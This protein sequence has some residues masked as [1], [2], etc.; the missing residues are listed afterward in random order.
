MPTPALDSQNRSSDLI[1]RPLR[2][3]H[4]CGPPYVHQEDLDNPHVDHMWNSRIHIESTS[5]H[6]R[7]PQSP[8]SPPVDEWLTIHTM[9]T[10]VHTS[11]HHSMCDHS[12]DME[13]LPVNCRGIFRK[14][15]SEPIMINGSNARS[16][17]GIAEHGLLS[18]LSSI[19]NLHSFNL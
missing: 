11:N 10:P 3:I 2:K 1:A 14:G 17:R 7:G 16:P 15:V 19:Q 18:P 9:S 13:S 6:S 8:C 12:E 5:G 4:T